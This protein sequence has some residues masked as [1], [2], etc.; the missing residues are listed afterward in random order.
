MIN[1]DAGVIGTEYII[2]LFFLYL[3]YARV[4]FCEETSFC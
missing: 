3:M 4:M 2:E 1:S